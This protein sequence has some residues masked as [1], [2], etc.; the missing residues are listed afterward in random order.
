MTGSFK[1]VAKYGTPEEAHLMRNQLEGAGIP[2][3][4]D[5][6]AMA[7]LG[8][9]ASNAMGSVKVLVPEEYFF[10][11]EEVLSGGDEEHGEAA[12]S[13][14]ARAAWMCPNCGERVDAGMDICW[15]CGTEAD[16]TESPAFETE[17]EEAEEDQPKERRAWSPE[18]AFFIILFPPTFAF[19]LFTKLCHVLAMLVP[20]AKHHLPAG[21]VAAASAVGAEGGYGRAPAVGYREGALTLHGEEPAEEPEEW[22][23]EP[24]EEELDGI[25]V[26]AWRAAVMGFFFF[27]PVVMTLYSAWLLVKY[28]L[29]RHR[30]NRRRDRWALRA[31]AVNLLATVCLGF[32]LGWTVLSLHD[33][34]T[35]APAEMGP[36]QEERAPQRGAGF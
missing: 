6:E 2:A 24:G 36:V 33:R 8:W 21:G 5:G 32:L 7:G 23:A 29:R 35:H 12:D 28:W 3:F 34:R 1:V 26:R 14:R 22:P 30:P 31:A 13:T 11:A 19:F 18:V 9:H 25:V 16:G 10:A 4:L 20:D 15:A 27:P 17:Q